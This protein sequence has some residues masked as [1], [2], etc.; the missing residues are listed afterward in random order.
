ML[1]GYTLQI[2]HES[3]LSQWSGSVMVTEILL[4]CV[5]C[6]CCG[7]VSTEPLPSSV[8]IH[9]DWCQTFMKYAVEMGACAMIYI[10]SFKKICSAIQKLIWCHMQTHREEDRTCHEEV[11][12]NGSI[13]P[14]FLTSDVDE[15]AWSASRPGS[16][17]SG[18]KSPV[19]I[20]WL[21]LRASLGAVEKRKISSP[22][23][24]SNHGLPVCK[25]S[26]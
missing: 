4:C 16:F 14:S 12:E 25:S 26:A 15:G 5:V 24:E 11:W 8:H 18:K 1:I 2:F 22:C 23:R 10:Q 19:P 6:C 13:A 3:S 7:N 21:D 17:T 9:T 20:G